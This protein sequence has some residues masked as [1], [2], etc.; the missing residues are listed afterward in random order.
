MYDNARACGSMDFASRLSIKF[1]QLVTRPD[2][3]HPTTLP[4]TTAL[5]IEGIKEL[6]AGIKDVSERLARLEATTA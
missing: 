4:E 5:L 6:G 2:T 1:S 3:M